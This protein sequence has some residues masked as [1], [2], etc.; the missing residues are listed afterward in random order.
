MDNK[1]E[2]LGSV[3]LFGSHRSR[4]R[5]GEGLLPHPERPGLGLGSGATTPEARSRHHFGE[6][7][8]L[9]GG[10][11][12]ATVRAEEPVLALRLD[13]S[14]FLALLDNHGSIGRKLLVE[15]SSRLR[16]AEGVLVHW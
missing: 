10:S 7:S 12:S 14:N 2:L 6:M 4:V 3:P 11:R 13:R 1:L 16:A 5:P 9:D 8:L 15:L